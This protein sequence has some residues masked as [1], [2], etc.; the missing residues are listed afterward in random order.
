M[1]NNIYRIILFIYA[2]LIL[3]MSSIPSSNLPK[4]WLLE[5]DKTIHFIEYFIFGILAMKSM[6]DVTRKNVLIIIP[7]G[8]LFGFVDEYLQSFILGRFSSQ[9]DII[10]DSLGFSI[11]VILVWIKDHDK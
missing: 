2:L 6:S 4:T 9:W 8:I 10:S 7:F 11:G 5:W 3:S 1:T